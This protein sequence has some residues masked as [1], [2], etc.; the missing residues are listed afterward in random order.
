MA[1]E[2]HVPVTIDE[3]IAGYPADTQERLQALRQT[4][5]AV[6]PEATEAINYGVPTFQLNGN[7]VHFGAS[8]N[9][10]GFYPSPS[11]M[12]AFEGRF[13][14]YKTAKGSVQ[15]PNDQPLP[16]GLVTEIVKFRVEEQQKKKK[17]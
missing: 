5:R 6:A 4:I 17:R 16:L 2:S 10:I 9:H 15:F 7:L 13:A 3:Y 1:G 12:T 14:G 8:K 11:A